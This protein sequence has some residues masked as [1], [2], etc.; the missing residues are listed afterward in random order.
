MAARYVLKENLSAGFELAQY[1]TTK[2]LVIDPVLIYST[3]LGGSS[4]EGFAGIAL[5]ETGNL[6]F[7]G[8]TG[9][10]DFPTLNPFQPAANGFFAVVTGVVFRARCMAVGIDSL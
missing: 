9:S 5:D 2:P 4:A 3:Y 1:D 8:D 6:Y 10:I 7:A